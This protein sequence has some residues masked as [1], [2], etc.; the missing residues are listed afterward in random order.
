[1]FPLRRDARHSEAA[2]AGLCACSAPQC[3]GLGW[4]PLPARAVLTAWG[5]PMQAAGCGVLS[6]RLWGQETPEPRATALYAS[7]RGA[8]GPPAEVLGNIPSSA[9]ALC[10][11]GSSGW[12]LGQTLTVFVAE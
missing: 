1:M 4:A 3:C 10:F 7:P 5:T 12:W 2:G 8:H 9:S 6:L 11:Q